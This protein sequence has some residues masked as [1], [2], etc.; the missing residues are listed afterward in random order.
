MRVIDNKEKRR[1]ETEIDGQFAIIEYSVMPNILSLNHIEVAEG[2]EGRGVAS[3]MTEK[4]LLE[5]ELRGLR[6]IA[7][8]P[9]IKNYI[10][11]HP[12][13]NSILAEGSK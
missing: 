8:C 12:E 7:V 1:F 10:Q 4:V 9:F 5:V 3:E 6:V 11:E 2:L 13:W